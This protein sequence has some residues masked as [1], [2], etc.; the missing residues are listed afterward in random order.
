M[1]HEKR[2]A[3][4]EKHS[5][6]MLEHL[7]LAV[8]IV[9]ASGRPL[10]MNRFALNLLGKSLE[11]IGSRDRV[12]NLPEVFM[13]Y[14]A[15]TDTVYPGERTPLAVALTGETSTVDDME[16]RRQGQT[17]P[18]EVSAAPIFDEKGEIAFAIAVFKDVADRKKTERELSLRRNEL[19]SLILKARA[20]RRRLQIL[21]RKRIEVQEAERGGIAR[22][23]HDEI[24]QALTAIK[25]N[26]QAAMGVS[27]AQSVAEYLK[28]GIEVVERV[29]QQVRNLSLDL[30]PSMLDDLGLT[31]SLRWYLDRQSQ[32]SGIKIVFMGD[33]SIKRLPQ[34]VETTCYRIVQEALTNVIRHARAS[35]VRIEVAP[36]NKGLE[37]VIRDNGMGFDLSE[38]MEH[39]RAG[40]SSGLLGMEERALLAGGEINIKSR[41]GKGTEIR[42]VIP[43]G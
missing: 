30:R 33:P 32:A 40:E 27:E 41:S 25:I 9:D 19:E 36:V 42:V 1:W 29:L 5:L 17:I 34:E 12:G 23:L 10:Y 13:A 38:A 28:E 6:K 43:G 11:E 20:G 21:S 14:V 26:L 15:G 3:L 16:I 35:E 8:F 37:L 7:P 24:G 4:I 2:Q 39:A 22:E 18:L 31:A